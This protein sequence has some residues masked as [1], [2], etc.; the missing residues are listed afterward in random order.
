MRRSTAAI[1]AVLL[2]SLSDNQ[3]L[4][5]VTDAFGLRPSSTSTRHHR[6]Q[7]TTTRLGLFDPILVESAAA[8]ATVVVGSSSS[9]SPLL[10]AYSEVAEALGSL[11]LLGS[12]GFGVFGGMRDPNFHYEYKVGNDGT[13]VGGGG[14]VASDLALLEVSPFPLLEE[15]SLFPRLSLRCDAMRFVLVFLY[16]PRRLLFSLKIISFI[17]YTIESHGI[18]PKT[19]SGWTIMAT[20]SP[21]Y[22]HCSLVR[23]KT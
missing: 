2:L 16:G 22:R 18:R 8:A 10:L 21:L 17:S 15:V 3:S 20:L 23:K 1:S 13:F 9:S 12:L 11:A 14:G 6:R 4:V 5:T 7:T 19:S